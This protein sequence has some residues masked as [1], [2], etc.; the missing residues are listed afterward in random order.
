MEAQ[1]GAL[2]VLIPEDRV[3]IAL[4]KQIKAWQGRLNLRVVSGKPAVELLCGSK[5]SL[6]VYWGSLAFLTWVR[7]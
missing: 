1:Q 4:V 3:R 2:E 6:A 5:L 7:N